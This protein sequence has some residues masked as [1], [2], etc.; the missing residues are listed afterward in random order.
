MRHAAVHLSESYVVPASYRR[1]LAKADLI[2]GHSPPAPDS[3]GGYFD[4]ADWRGRPVSKANFLGRWTFL[5]FGYSRCQG[6]CQTAAPL[7][8]AAASALRDRGYSATAAFVDIEAPPLITIRPLEPN[9]EHSHGSNWPKRFAMALLALRQGTDLEVLT[10][11]RFQ[12]AQATAAY[13]VLR[14]H[15]PPRPEEVNLSINH[16]SAIYLIGPDTLV[17]GFG[18]HDMEIP[19]MVEMVEALSKAE[20]NR[21]DLAA[22]RRRYI[23]GAC[24]A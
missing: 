9:G 21:I 20:R 17:A 2:Y 13:H 18:Y 16:S 7:I 8:A 19:Q 3:L 11:N 4:F 6:T 1:R 22:V 24:G 5:Y 23:K 14:E 12:L 10:G 15:V